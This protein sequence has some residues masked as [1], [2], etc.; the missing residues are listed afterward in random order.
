MLTLPGNIYM[1]IA[2]KFKYFFTL[3]VL[4]L[5]IMLMYVLVF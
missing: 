2:V 5:C 3:T 4:L 1:N